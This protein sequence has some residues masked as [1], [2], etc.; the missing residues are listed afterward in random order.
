[1][2]WANITTCK[3]I[4]GH[5]SWYCRHLEAM[6]SPFSLPKWLARSSEMLLVER[7]VPYRS[8]AIVSLGLGLGFGGMAGFMWVMMYSCWLLMILGNH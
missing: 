8:K 1:M 7:S 2:I 3:G 6:R 5:S 4:Y